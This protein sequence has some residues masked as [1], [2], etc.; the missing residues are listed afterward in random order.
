VFLR[1]VRDPSRAPDPEGALSWLYRVATNLCLND[2]RSARRRARF[3]ARC[4]DQADALAGEEALAARELTRRIAAR[5]PR[6]LTVSAV[7][8]HVDGMSHEEVA[9]ALGMSR[10]TVIYHLA[11]FRAR[12]RR[13]VGGGRDGDRDDDSARL[14]AG[15]GI[16]G[17]A[18]RG[19]GAPGPQSTATS[20]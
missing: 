7:L 17:H 16:P 15:S 19:N 9:R 10:R 8:Y 20:P 1:L 12:A 14:A 5:T 4:G 18:D 11:Q 2:V 13:A 3:A 6:R